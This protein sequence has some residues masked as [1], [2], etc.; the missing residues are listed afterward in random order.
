M[1][2]INLSNDKTKT[3]ANKLVHLKKVYKDNLF[4]KTYILHS[5]CSS[6]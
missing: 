2:L 4:I 5:G 3:V 6:K 1:E